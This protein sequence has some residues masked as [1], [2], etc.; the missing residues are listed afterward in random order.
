MRSHKAK[1]FTESKDSPF[2]FKIVKMKLYD[3]GDL[4]L[5]FDESKATF[6]A[7]Q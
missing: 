2:A 1:R 4:Y 5:E 6:S 7:L 3:N